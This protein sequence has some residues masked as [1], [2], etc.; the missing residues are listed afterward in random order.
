MT[1]TYVTAFMKIYDV[2][3]DE[4]VNGR[5]LEARL[6]YVKPLLGTQIPLVIFI[7]P[8]YLEAVRA[9]CPKRP[10][11]EFVPM[12]LTETQTWNLLQPFQSKIPVHRNTAK[13]T[14][15]FLTLMNAKAEFVALAAASNVFSTDQFAWIDFS[16]FHVLQNAPVSQRKLEL[17]C[18]TVLAKEHPFTVPGCWR[19]EYK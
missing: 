1:L 8:C 12:E 17:L 13:D 11:T 6:N 7:S 10:K 2:G 3:D 4:K 19:K 15:E 16:I 9:L 14:F 18:N 5:N